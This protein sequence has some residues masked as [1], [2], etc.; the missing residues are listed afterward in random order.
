MCALWEKFP[1]IFLPDSFFSQAGILRLA[2]RA[3]LQGR[4][5]GLG[6]ED[7]DEVAGVGKTERMRDF[8]DRK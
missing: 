6:A 5:S 3:K 2:V 4:A 1:S 7:A 8:G